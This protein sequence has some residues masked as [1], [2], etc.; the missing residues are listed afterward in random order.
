MNINTS[1]SYSN[2]EPEKSFLYM[3]GT[4]IGNLDDISFRAIKI[5]KYLKTG[6]GTYKICQR[7][8]KTYR[9]INSFVYIHIFMYIFRIV[10]IICSILFYSSIV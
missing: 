8:Y 2:Q 7:V 5:L 1:L 6:A 3:V 9:Y 4:P 10:L